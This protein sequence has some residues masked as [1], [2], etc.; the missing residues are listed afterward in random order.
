MALMSFKGEHLIDHLILTAVLFDKIYG[1]RYTQMLSNKLMRLNA[2]KALYRLLKLACI[3]H[4]IGKAFKGYQE[5]KGHMSF[6]F[7]EIPS[8]QIFIDIAMPYFY[9]YQQLVNCC[10]IAILIHHQAMRD[11]NVFEENKSKIIEEISKRLGV[12]EEADKDLDELSMAISRHVGLEIK[13]QDLKKIIENVN[14]NTL[15]TTLNTLKEF[16]VNNPKVIDTSDVK[17]QQW[18]SMLSAPIQ[19][20]DNLAA[21]LIRPEGSPLTRRLAFEALKL[22]SSK[23]ELKTIMRNKMNDVGDGCGS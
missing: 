16:Y 22:L 7:H 12:P 20:C 2:V 5:Q 11:L 3:L 21:S 1:I 14:I 10:G 4:D 8:A 15:M 6:P 23:V 17:V 9:H 13:S 19:L 18:V